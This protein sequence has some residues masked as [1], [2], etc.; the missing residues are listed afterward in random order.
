[1]AAPVCGVVLGT[2]GVAG[3]ILVGKFG[4]SVGKVI[5]EATND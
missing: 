3:G 1:M 5:C 4:E 2:S